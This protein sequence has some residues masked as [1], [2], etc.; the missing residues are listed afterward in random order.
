M[1]I[2]LWKIYIYI[3]F[4]KYTNKDIQWLKKVSTEECS[5]DMCTPDQSH[6]LA[7][8]VSVTWVC[9]CC[10]C[11]IESHSV[12]QA[13][14][15]TEKHPNPA[16]RFFLVPRLLAQLSHEGSLQK[17]PFTEW[18]LGPISFGHLHTRSC[19]RPFCKN[20]GPPPLLHQEL[21]LTMLVFFSQCSHYLAGPRSVALKLHV[22][23]AG[24]VVVGWMVGRHSKQET[25]GASHL[26]IYC[27]WL[28]IL[29]AGNLQK[30][31]GFCP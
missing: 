3:I 20:Q 12:F 11:K 8:S 27:T 18:S 30:S 14:P 16:W 17:W 29:L 31:F 21:P 2:H 28:Y 5:D 9:L 13:T 26:G 19:S 22:S 7:V 15:T 10:L 24:A 4:F 6:S 1:C 23:H 25:V